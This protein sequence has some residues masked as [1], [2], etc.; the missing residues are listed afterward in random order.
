MGCRQLSSTPQE[1]EGLG[2]ISVDR[3]D[4]A[5]LKDV[6]AAGVDVLVD[7][8]PYERRDAEQLLGLRDLVGSVVAISSASVYADDQGRSLDTIPRG[9]YPDLPNP[10]PESQRTVPPG[11]E[12]YST[13]KAAIEQLLLGQNELPA[14]VIRPCA[15]Y[16]QGDTLCR[17]W[18]FLK[19][20]L[21]RRPHVLLAYEGKSVF[22][23][24]SVRNV[25]EV[26]RLAAERP[27]TRDLNCGDPDPPAVLRISRTIADVVGH[28]WEEILVPP[29]RSQEPFV[30][31]PWAAPRALI[32]DMRKAKDELGYEPVTTYDDAITDTIEWVRNI[33]TPIDWKEALPRAAEYFA[34]R[35]DYDAE[36]AF[37]RGLS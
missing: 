31:N 5:A 20:A 1:V 2:Q 23:T 11:D 32:V 15:I 10:I 29:D 22:H 17:E 33:A 9:E 19:R 27:G 3:T 4:D 7:V 28:E 8:I 24:S 26:V 30:K 34:K 37:V 6:L 35:F 13:K 21:D 14:T 12:T 36:D 16:G 18:F 25:T